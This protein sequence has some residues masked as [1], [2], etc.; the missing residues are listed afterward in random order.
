MRTFISSRGTVG[1]AA[2]TVFTASTLD[3]W[4]DIMLWCMDAAN[5]GGEGV[6][7]SYLR[8]AIVLHS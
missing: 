4:S 5:D 3:S 2:L 7:S 6:G 1:S 8:V